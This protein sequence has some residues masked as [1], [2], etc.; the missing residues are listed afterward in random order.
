MEKTT[1]GLQGERGCVGCKQKR[2]WTYKMANLPG[3][4]RKMGV[5]IRPIQIANN[6]KA[7]TKRPPGGLA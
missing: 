6:A 4:T 5:N 2:E 7:A 3:L 1:V